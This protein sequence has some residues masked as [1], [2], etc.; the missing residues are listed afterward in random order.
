VRISGGIGFLNSDGKWH[1]LAGPVPPALAGGDPFANLDLVRGT[2]RILSDGGAEV[3]GASTIR[4]TVTVDPARA[5]LATPPARRP[6]LQVVLEGRV[7]RFNMDVWIDSQDRIRRVEVPTNLRA[8]TP[9]TRVDRLPIA[10]DV[11]YIDFG[12]TV[13]VEPAPAAAGP[14]GGP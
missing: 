2:V 14:P 4:Y 3:D 5:I 7:S 9:P 10:T 11:D 8:E 13:A 12:V 1:Q 6:A